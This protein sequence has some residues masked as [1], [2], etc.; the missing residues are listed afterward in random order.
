MLF[1]H[2]KE[3]W[4]VALNRSFLQLTSKRFRIYEF[5]FNHLQDGFESLLF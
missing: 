4:Q 2:L 1:I 5:T 3:E